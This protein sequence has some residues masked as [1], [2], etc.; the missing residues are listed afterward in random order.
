MSK[1]KQQQQ[2]KETPPLQE[3]QFLRSKVSFDPEIYNE[4]EHY[5]FDSQK[6]ANLFA[7]KDNEKKGR[8]SLEKVELILKSFDKFTEVEIDSIRNSFKSQTV[9][10]EDGLIDLNQLYEIMNTVYK[11]RKIEVESEE[12][13]DAFKMFDRDSNGVISFEEMRSI[14]L[15]FSSD[16]LTE[17]EITEIFNEVDTNHDGSI[18][19]QEFIQFYKKNFI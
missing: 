4:E 8:I 7:S 2:Q 11:L 18:D 3:E 9:N 17:Q 14:L 6:L 16:K 1:T 13:L 15:N 19:Y 10:S 12:I 5:L